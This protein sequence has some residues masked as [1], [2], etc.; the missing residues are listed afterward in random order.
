VETAPFFSTGDSNYDGLFGM[1]FTGASGSSAT[2]FMEHLIANG[3]V[4]APEFSFNL[5]R[6][7]NGNTGA[8]SELI[9]GGRNT[10]MY[11]GSITQVPVV[12][13]TAWIVN[14]ASISVNGESAGANIN[15][16]AGIDTG[17]SFIVVPVSALTSIFALIPGAVQI[18]IASNSS[19]NLIMYAY[20]CDTDASHIP[21]MHLG[22]GN[23]AAFSI[24]PQDFNLGFVDGTFAQSL[25]SKEG[26][27]QSVIQGEGLCLASLLGVQD[28]VNPDLYVLGTPFLKSW[29]SVFHYG[30][31]S[32]GTWEGAYVGFARSVNCQGVGC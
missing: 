17:T 20:P 21:T 5:G 11:R 9:L 2:T 28:N 1:A 13:Q 19:N 6:D 4:S 10:T 27:T 23:G 12:N 3:Q 25:A 15:G 31:K 30:Q 16:L 18:P 32:Q 24:D 22:S 7:F 26:T 8:N 14:M 29:Y